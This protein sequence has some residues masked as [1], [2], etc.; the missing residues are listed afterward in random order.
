M[1]VLRIPFIGILTKS[2]LLPIKRQKTIIG[3]PLSY[4]SDQ[5]VFSVGHKDSISFDD[6]PLW[7]AEGCFVEITVFP[8]ALR[9]Y[10]ITG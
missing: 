2:D 4:L 8:T 10:D 7:G 5:M 9:P 3:Q 6:N 1:E